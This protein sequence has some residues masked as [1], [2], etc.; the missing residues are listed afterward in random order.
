MRCAAVITVIGRS[1]S[2]L[3]AATSSN[4]GNTSRRSASERRVVQDGA[5]RAAYC[6]ADRSGHAQRAAT[7]VGLASTS[8]RPTTSSGYCR[9][10]RDGLGATEGVADDDVRAG[11]AG[12]VEQRVEVGGLRSSNVCGVVGASLVPVPNRS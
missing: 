10:E 6:A 8:M 2:E 3:I 11:L 5:E 4:A 12:G 9:R 7:S 1:P